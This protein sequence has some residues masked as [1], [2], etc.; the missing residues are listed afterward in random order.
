MEE[1][2]HSIRRV[3]GKSSLP[4]GEWEILVKE[5]I[6]SSGGENLSASDFDHLDLFQS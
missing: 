4:A 2:S 3:V 6:F 1:F 5:V